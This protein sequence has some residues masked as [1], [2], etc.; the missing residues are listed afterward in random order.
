MSSSSHHPPRSA[1]RPPPPLDQAA[2]EAAAIFYLQRFQT[3]RARLV[4]VLARKLRQRGWAEDA[5]PPDIEALADRMA[6]LGYVNDSIF[7]EARARGLARRGMGAMR[8]KAA[9]AAHGIDADDQYAALAGHEAIA[10]AVAFARRRRFGPFGP[11]IADQAM[12]QRQ[13]AAMARAGHP[14]DLSRRI[15]DAQS[16]DELPNPEDQD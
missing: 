11:A 13:L 9:L 6:E 3:S 1:R 10:V 8:V 14:L 5:P 2:L 15:I 4:Q 7:A 12:R 16:E